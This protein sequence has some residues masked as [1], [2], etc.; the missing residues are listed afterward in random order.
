VE[1]ACPQDKQGLGIT[2]RSTQRCAAQPVVALLGAL[3]PHV[4]SGAKRWMLA[5]APAI[6]RLGIK[7]LVR[8]VVG[9]TGRVALDQEG[10]VRQSMLTQAHRLARHLRAAL[11]M[12]A[13]SADVAVCSGET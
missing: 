11:Q 5:R 12:L 2:K 13:S 7:Q 1:T 8:A 9:I 3:A 4:L 10:H 6:Q